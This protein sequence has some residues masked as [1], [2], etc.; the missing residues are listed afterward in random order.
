MANK[1]KVLVADAISQEGIDILGENL[2]VAYEPKITAEE[3]LGKIGDFD[4]LL[5]RSRTKVPAEVIKQGRK[6]KVIGRAGV[7]VDNIDVPAA[8]EAGI[9]VLNS[10]EGNTASAAEHTLALLM[11]LARLLPAADRSV[12]EGRWERERFTGCELFNKTLA[13]IGLGK[14][15]TRVA[16][17]AQSLGMKVV[18][19]DPLITTERAA[20]LNVQKLPLEE[21]WPKADFITVHAPKT[22]ETSNMIDSV[23]ISKM[24][25]GV[26]IINAA[27]GG[28]INEIAL[29]KAIEEG[30]V[31]GAAVDVFEKEPPNGS[32]LLNLADKVVL[33]PHLGA[34]THEAQFNVA[35]DLAEQI[36]DY[37]KTGIAKSPV[38][39][40]SMRPEVMKEL[41]GNVWLAEAM[42]TIAAE[43]NSG[44]IRSLEIVAAGR[45]AAKDNAPL[46][47]AGLR[48]ILS[49]R[50]EGVTYVNAQLIARNNGIQVRASKSEDTTQYHDELT[51]IASSEQQVSSLSGTILA[52]NEPL[53][54]KINS[55]PINLNPVPMMLF[56]CHKDRPGMVAKVAGVLQN[57]DVNISNMSLARVG[58]RQEAV[59]VMGV[60]DPLGSEILSELATIDGINTAHFVSLMRPPQPF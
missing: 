22:P 19:Y 30:K 18:V 21:I 27:R 60:D 9:V 42:G 3:L 47:V 55:Y 38:N 29:A 20:Q 6:L 34:S 8:T 33:T 39:L 10:P 41:G 37:L 16:V 17:A 2:S 32:P 31:A 36:R 56:T 46:V 52:H 4:A 51:V 26:R 53:I 59:M 7:G 12:K 13:I 24:K 50:I 43:L 15:G 54:T 25:R 14:V 45:L 48:G 1:H 35:I 58:V 40:P 49:K 28:I 11:T 57:H 23:A 5:V 44:N